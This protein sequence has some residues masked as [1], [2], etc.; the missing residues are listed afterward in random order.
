MPV[1]FKD[2]LLAFEF[3]SSGGMEHQACLCKQSGTFYWHSELAGDLDELPD[4]IDDSDKYVQIPDKKELDLGKP[5]VLDFARQFLQDD[6]G[7][8]QEIFSKR[9]AYAR[10][11]D[12]LQRRGALDQWY[13]FEANAQERAL[14][15][16]CDLNSIEVGD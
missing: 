4:D 13:A 2:I 3:V 6:V 1:S 10:F 14:R 11:K 8:V 5:L 16:W 9:G 15:M 7:D 12:L